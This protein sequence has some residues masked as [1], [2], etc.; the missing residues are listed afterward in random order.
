MY[1]RH[2]SKRQKWALLTGFLALFLGW[3]TW[4]MC[5]FA[6]T[7]KDFYQVLRERGFND[8]VAKRIQLHVDVNSQKQILEKNLQPKTF[9]RG[10][11]I[12]IGK[13]DPQFNRDDVSGNVYFAPFESWASDY[14]AVGGLILKFQIPYFPQYSG[15]LVMER[16]ESILT[17]SFFRLIKDDRHYLE[18][19][20]I[21]HGQR[22]IEW[23]TYDKA[24]RD[25]WIQPL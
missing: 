4:S 1:P 11:N 15:V 9:Y 12:P 23:K 16:R 2:T 6:V 22:N 5:D 8:S 21:V 10:V 17:N 14:T 24:V 7:D 19:I 20:G 3:E 13:Y 25:G 18:E